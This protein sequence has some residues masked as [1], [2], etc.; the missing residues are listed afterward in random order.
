MYK[1][2]NLILPPTQSIMFPKID[3]IKTESWGKLKLHY[4]GIAE[5]HLK[6][7]FKEDPR[8]FEEFSQRNGDILFDY[9]KNRISKDTITLLIKLAEECKLG[10]AIES[11]FNGEL[12]NETENRAVLHTALRNFSGQP[13]I[14]AGNDVMPDVIRIQKQMKAFCERVHSG[15]WKGYSGKKIRY[16]VN[17]GIG[18]SDLGPYM[19]TEALRPYDW[20][21]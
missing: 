15:E 14:T 18:G 12:I 4:K 8:R 7:L 19:V 6:D 10:E 13:M 1:K 5:K 17:I 9:S 16:I 2:T 11:M 3:P 21:E 20:M